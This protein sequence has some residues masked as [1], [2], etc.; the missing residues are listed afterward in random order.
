MNKDKI[1]KLEKGLYSRAHPHEYTDVRS[2]ISRPEILVGDPRVTGDSV[3]DLVRKSREEQDNKHKRIFTKILLASVIF[4]LIALGIGAYSFFAGGNSV[5]AGNIDIVVVGPTSVPGGQELP[6]QIT[7]QNK[8]TAELNGVILNVT[9]PE[10]T[11]APGDLKTALNRQSF[12][13]GTIPA[14]GQTSIAAK[15][16]PFGEKDSIQKIKMN[17]EY[18]VAGGSALFSKEKNYDIGISSSPVIITTEFPSEVNSNQD[19]PVTLRVTSNTGEL[20]HNVLVNLQYPFGFT[21]TSSEPKPAVGTDTWSIGDL[22]TGESRTIKLRGTLQGQDGEQRTFKMSV[23]L[24][25]DKTPS[26]ISNTL[27]ILDNTVSIKKS[28]ISLAVNVGGKSA[29]EYVAVLG[30]KIPIIISWVNNLSSPLLN[31]QIQVK[32]EGDSLDK[33]SVLT[34]S[35]GF[36]R[37]IDNTII[38]DKSNSTGF[39]SI[40]PGDRGSVSFSLAPLTTIPSSSRNQSIKLAITFTGSQIGGGNTPQTMI[41]DASKTIKIASPFGFSARAVRSIGPFENSGPIPPKAEKETTYT[42]IWAV[43]NPFNDLQ[44]VKVIAALPSYV[45][46]NNL[47]NPS[48][49]SVTYEKNTNNVTWNAG[50]VSAGTGTSVPQRTASFQIKLLPSLGQV[51]TGPVLI[52]DIGITGSDS[53]TGQTLNLTKPLITTR[54]SSDPQF[55]EGDDIVGK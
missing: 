1:E 33:S 14:R 45:S 17:L 7:V 16:V 34:N 15:S 6:L 40:D 31:A 48:G 27:S 51:G 21:F 9:Y 52:G 46:W 19:F 18:R 2:D 12:N 49:E 20:L 35:S 42:V 23:G 28:S 38:F 32:I 10:G 13:I 29:D 55:K 5:S 44:N 25:D 30:Q 3:E 43:S 41:A 26:I 11:K 39:N 53:F 8:N 22:Q 37:S 47:V 24:A 54:I 50:T 36:Y 4:F